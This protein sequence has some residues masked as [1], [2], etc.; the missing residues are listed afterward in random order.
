MESINHIKFKNILITGGAGF[1]GGCMV[2]ELIKNENLNIFNLDKLGY[3]SDL[4]RINKKLMH[5]GESSFKRYKFLKVDLLNKKETI[6]AIENSNPDLI[7]HFAAESHVDNSISS[8]EPFVTN[9]ILSTLNILNATRIYLSKNE[10]KRS[11]FKLIQIST[12]EVFGS[13]GENG[14]FSEDSKYDPRSPYSASKASSD[15]LA[16]AWFH[17]F[18]LPIITTNCSNNYGPWQFPEKLIPV[19]IAKALKHEKIPLYG[20]GG[21]IR[22]WLFVEDHINAL[23]KIINNGKIGNNY[24]IG[25]NCEKTN[26]DLIME[27]CNKLNLIFDNNVNYRELITPVEDRKGHDRRYAIDNSRIKN[28]LGWVPHYDFSKGMD[29]TIKWYLSNKDWLFSKT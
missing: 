10:K 5:L 17:T 3:A 8:P 7:L 28:E 12:D 27:I 15:H 21:N 4:S 26:K 25:G 14:F 16:N 11:F 9:N 6:E 13:L 2:N 19:V 22:D 29:I 18:N 23:I 1:I 24:C 20:D